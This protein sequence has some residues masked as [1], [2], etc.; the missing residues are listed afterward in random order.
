MT[1]KAKRKIRR[2]RKPALDAALA[3]IAQELKKTDWWSDKMAAIPVKRVLPAIAVPLALGFFICKAS[4]LDRFIGYREGC[5]YIP[6]IHI[7][8]H[9][10]RDAI[11]HEYGHALLYCH[12]KSIRKRDFRKIFNGKG[13]EKD[14]VSRYAMEDPIE[15]FCETFMVY[16]RSG[17]ELPARFQSTAVASKWQFLLELSKQ[18]RAIGAYRQR[19]EIGHRLD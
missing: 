19:G 10:L 11:R 15:D 6:M 13:G 18:I 7:H 2:I 17:G 3:Q 12:S 4:M 9:S 8:E 16:V 5:I 14:F 1:S